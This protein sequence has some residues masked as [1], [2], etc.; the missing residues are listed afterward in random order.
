MTEVSLT[1][2]ISTL[3][4]LGR[5]CGLLCCIM[6]LLTEERTIQCVI[7]SILS[8]KSS[9]SREIRSR[10][11]GTPLHGNRP[12]FTPDWLIRLPVTQV[13]VS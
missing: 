9:A 11:N 10:A 12:R 8:R 4:Y 3:P 5:T 13:G 2:H 7:T 1:D 6:E